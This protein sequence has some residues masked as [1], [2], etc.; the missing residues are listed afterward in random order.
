MYLQKIDFKLNI[1][2]SK[3]FNMKTFLLTFSVFSLGLICF[4]Q[5]IEFCGSLNASSEQRFK[6]SPGIGIQY[7]HY[8]GK[9]YR[10]GLGI[11]YNF[12]NAH[13]DYIPVVDAD[14]T[15]VVAEEINSNSNC[16]SIRLNI[17]RLLKNDDYVSISI[18]PEVSYNYLWGKDRIAQRAS[19]PFS[20][21]EFSQT[22]ELKKAIGI[23][24]VSKVEIKNFIVSKLS[25]CLTF[26]PELLFGDNR[27][28]F[29]GD[30]PVFSGIWTF[31]E[32]QLGL[33]YRFK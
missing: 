9:N 22:N 14:P 1:N 29:G 5:E 13:F 31:S 11:H 19:P 15:A 28:V 7:Q 26:K 20:Y 3:S 24:L 12:K 6:N 21:S 16:V 17:Q 30:P 25:L 4:G 10:V 27:L 18:G 33:K 8:L 32:F 2:S 23:G